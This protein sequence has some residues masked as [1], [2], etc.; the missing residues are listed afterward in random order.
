MVSSEESP[1]D[2]ILPTVTVVGAGGIGCALAHAM[3]TGGV[4]VTLVEVD[5]AKLE[6]GRR[7]G[8]R[9]DGLP[10]RSVKVMTVR[11]WP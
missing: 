2:Q 7:H 6:W 9:V 5:H 1:L 10:P 3:R 8:V 4:E 11:L